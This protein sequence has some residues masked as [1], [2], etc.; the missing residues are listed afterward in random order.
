MTRS[1]FLLF[2][3]MFLYSC[4]EVPNVK[5][6]EMVK[7]EYAIVIHGGAGTI[8]KKNM[9]PEKEKS[10]FGDGSTGFVHQLEYRRY[11]A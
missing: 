5:T 4:T 7:P 2:I 3:A 9:T 10:Y 8:L 11:L 6:T 1:V